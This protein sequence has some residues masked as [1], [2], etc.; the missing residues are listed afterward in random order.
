MALASITAIGSYTPEEKIDNKWFESRIETND[1]WIQTRTGIKTRHFAREDEFTSDLCVNAARDLAE[2]YQKDLSD[3]DMIFVASVTPDQTMP[4]AASQIQDKLGLEN[5]G[6]LD[7]NAACAGFGYGIVLARG[8]IAAGSHKKVLVFGAET[9]TKVTDFTD[10]TSC[11]LFGDAAGVVLIEA[12]EEDG[13]FSGVTGSM[14][15]GGKDLY[16]S[17]RNKI[18]NG[19]EIETNGLI[20]Q[21]GRAVFKWAVSTMPIRI[22]EILAKSPYELSDLDWIIPHSANMRILD[23]IAADL[24]FP[25]EKMLESVSDC[26]NTSSATIPLALD[27]GIKAGKVKPGDKIIF[28]GFGGGLTYAGI[29]VHWK[30]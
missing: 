6:A 16:I 24:D 15:A 1:E 10:R 2:R 23:A 14:G 3:V 27:K 19:E 28:M 22:R 12:S 29:G 11:I 25:T 20:H 17:E 18:V 21:N 26:G 13:F 8:L 7:I 4:S 9:L 30:I 5:T